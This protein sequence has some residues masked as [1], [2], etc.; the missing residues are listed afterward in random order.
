MNKIDELFM[1]KHEIKNIKKN[2]N[3]QKEKFNQKH[4]KNKK[5]IILQFILI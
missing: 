2:S 4:R 1:D 3:F 5:K